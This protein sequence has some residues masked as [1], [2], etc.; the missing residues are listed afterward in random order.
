[1]FDTAPSEEMLLDAVIYKEPLIKQKIQ[2]AEQWRKAQSEGSR[3]FIKLDDNRSII[4]SPY[5]AEQK[6]DIVFP[7]GGRIKGIWLTEPQM[8]IHF[9]VLFVR[10]LYFIGGFVSSVLTVLLFVWLWYFALARLRE[11]SQAIRGG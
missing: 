3:L 4:V 10:L 2:T 6:A 9:P 7:D 1:M 8:R 5:S 11:L